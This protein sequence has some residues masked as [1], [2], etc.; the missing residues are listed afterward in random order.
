M[1]RIVVAAVAVGLVASALG[2]ASAAPRPAKLRAAPSRSEKN[3]PALSDL[4][5]GTALS[6]YK[7]GRPTT[8]RA[9]LERALSLHGSSSGGARVARA[10]SRDATMILR[11]LFVRV[12]DLSGAERALAERVLARP[13]DR[14]ALPFRSLRADVSPLC[15]INICV[16]YTT[17]GADAPEPTDSD[18]DG[19]PDYVETVSA[20]FEEVWTEE[21]TR[22]GFRAPLPDVPGGGR[23]N[24][25]TRLD[26]YIQDLGAEGL[27]GFCQPEAPP[28]AMFFNVPG[29]CAVDN[30]FV[31]AQFPV[32]ANGLEALRVTAA[33][34]FFHAVQF[35]YDVAEDRWFME[36]TAAWMED[37]I[38]DDIND[39]YQYLT[40]SAVK[41]PAVPV[42]YGDEGFQYGSFLFF[43]YLSELF[44]PGIILEIWQR[45]D[46]SATGPDDY[47]TLAI[48]NALKMDGA[49]FGRVFANFAAANYIAN[50]VYEE[51]A[52][53]INAVGFPPDASVRLKARRPS[54]VGNFPID[55]MSTVY[56]TLK[57]GK[58]ISNDAKLRVS[59]DLPKLSTGSRATAIV[60]KRNGPSQVVAI[61]TNS[62]GEG[63]VK[64][65]FS[66]RRVLKVGVALT[67]ASTRFAD[68]YAA[69]TPFSCMGIPID[70]GLNYHI[71]AKALN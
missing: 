35:A 4:L 42:D 34:E 24:P 23:A 32:G 63:K 1:K 69:G 37:E 16:H 46:G 44:G 17:A 2:S 20:T 53:Y 38:Y 47:S 26:V 56:A 27:Y 71:T 14:R 61:K 36:G 29:F 70:D 12:D 33:H 9:A 68:C 65:T 57:P 5:H 18:G 55:H 21:V 50:E 43:R 39:N 48:E 64:V 60:R 31:P 41:F 45:A 62:S 51:G 40:T 3:V 30:D 7:S 15:S 52:K 67:N 28:G 13:T 6:A 66:K 8:A 54:A 19:D 10:G 58:G 11:D 22:M 49:I 59:V 25:D